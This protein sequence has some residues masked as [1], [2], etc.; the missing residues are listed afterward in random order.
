MHSSVEVATKKQDKRVTRTRRLLCNALV[1]LI[2]EHGYDP[3]TVSHIAERANVGRAT[4]YLHYHDKEQLLT[5]TVRQGMDGLMESM[6]KNAQVLNQSPLKTLYQHAADNCYLYCVIHSKQGSAAATRLIREYIKNV[7]LLYLPKKHGAIPNEL[8]ACHISG[9]L[10]SIIEWWLGADMPY[11]VE[12]M[13]LYSGEM[14]VFG[15][16]HEL[17][18]DLKNLWKD[19]KPII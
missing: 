12:E 5:D 19:R 3:L 11:T 14:L 9:S 13:V 1:D 15:V 6:E 16:E 18:S 4:F 8:V 10:F 17:K 2:L 7:V